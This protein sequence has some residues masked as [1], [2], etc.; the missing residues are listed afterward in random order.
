MKGKKL[1]AG[2]LSAAMVIGTMAVPAFADDST[3]TVVE[4]LEAFKTA[5]S[6]TS[7]K[8]ITVKGTIDVSSVSFSNVDGTKIKGDPSDGEDVLQLKGALGTKSIDFE[9]LTMEWPNANYQ[10]FTGSTKITYNNVKII[11][12]PFLGICTRKKYR[13]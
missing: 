12:Q 5:L 1:L 6:D 13:G 9:D 11:G 7:V 10:G 3:A 4:T 2:T 8:E